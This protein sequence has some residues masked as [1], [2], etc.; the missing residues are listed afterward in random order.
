MKNQQDSSKGKINFD[1][2]YDGSYNDCYK[3]ILSGFHAY[4]KIK[5]DLLTFRNAKY[6]LKYHFNDLLESSG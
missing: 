4:E 3:W 1:L 2:T 5:L 6:L